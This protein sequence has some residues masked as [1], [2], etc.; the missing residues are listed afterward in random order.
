VYLATPSPICHNRSD[1]QEPKTPTLVVGVFILPRR[2]QCS[3]E[4]LCALY[5]YRGDAVSSSASRV[6]T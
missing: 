2:M 1:F 4:F 3:P 5:I 6:D